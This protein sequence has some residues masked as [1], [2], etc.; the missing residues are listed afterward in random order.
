MT[1]QPPTLEQQQIIDYVGECLIK[2]TPNTIVVQAYAGCGKTSTAEMVCKSQANNECRVL[3]LSF[4]KDIQ[5]SAVERFKPL[6]NVDVRTFDS[7]AREQVQE[8]RPVSGSLNEFVLRKNFNLNF[9]QSR[10]AWQELKQYLSSPD[11]KTLL[12]RDAISVW[13]QLNTDHPYSYYCCIR[14]RYYNLLTSL[15]ER[16]R[17]KWDTTDYQIVIVDECQDLNPIMLQSCLQYQGVLLF[18]GDTNQHIFDFAGTCDAFEYFRD[19]VLTR[20][21][22]YFQLS[23][24]FRFGREVSDV[25]R[26]IVKSHRVDIVTTDANRDVSTVIVGE[27][28]DERMTVIKCCLLAT[29]VRHEDNQIANY[30]YR[31]MAILSRCNNTVIDT[32]ISLLHYINGILSTKEEQVRCIHVLGKDIIYRTIN[33]MFSQYA[34]FFSRD[35]ARKAFQKRYEQAVQSENFDTSSM[36]GIILKYEDEIPLLLE[37]IELYHCEDIDKVPFVVGTIYRAKGMEFDVV[38]VIDDFDVEKIVRAKVES[39]FNGKKKRNRNDHQDM[40][41]YGRMLNSERIRIKKQKER[42]YYVAATRAKYVL[43]VPLSVTQ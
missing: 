41:L 39:T 27:D 13:R 10:Y 6:G 1:S 43:N 28:I 11:T 18:I 26:Q 7:W 29:Y 14:R 3:Y 42:L 33:T 25:A 5:K 17:I 37:R 4:G 23:L 2:K 19:G 36:L 24:S 31:Q 21:P 32:L 40:G 12:N 16:H 30:K 9:Y 15:D 35:E 22:K 8:T 34:A 20:A 38:K